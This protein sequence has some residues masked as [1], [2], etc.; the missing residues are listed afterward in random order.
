MRVPMMVPFGVV[1]VVPPFAVGALLCGLS[2]HR[3]RGSTDR[4]GHSANR[5]LRDERHGGT[6]EGRDGSIPSSRGAR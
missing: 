5:N 2:G 1:A 6:D 4:Q 3:M